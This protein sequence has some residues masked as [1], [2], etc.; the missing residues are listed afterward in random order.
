MAE[1][2]FRLVAAGVTIG[3]ML[4]VVIILSHESQEQIQPHSPNLQNQNEKTNGKTRQLLQQIK[5]EPNSTVGSDIENIEF[6][7]DDVVQSIDSEWLQ[8][9]L[10]DPKQLVKIHARGEMPY[11]SLAQSFDQTSLPEFY[12]ILRNSN[13]SGYEL[14]QAVIFIG[15]ISKRGNNESVNALKDFIQREVDWNK[16]QHD[17]DNITISK[18]HALDW[19][20]YLGGENVEEFLKYAITPEGARELAKQ[21]LN[22]V[23]KSAFTEEAVVDNLRGFAAKGLSFSDDPAIHE[24]IRSEY[25]KEKQACIRTGVIGTH[26]FN[27]LC[28]AVTRID[29]IKV[30][31][32]EAHCALYDGEGSYSNIYQKYI[33]KYLLFEAIEPTEK[34]P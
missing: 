12:E 33:R 20:G 27:Q 23:P 4:L 7:S 34:H 28:G 15:Q 6:I 11:Y 26:Y 9:M 14:D 31:G 30:I 21:W 22:G 25:E 19:L 17:A 3:F 29:I 2:R 18:W 1:R 24:L 16:W 13:S 10:K 5:Q 32:I 8:S